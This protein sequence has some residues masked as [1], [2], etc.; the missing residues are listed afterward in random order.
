[1]KEY[2]LTTREYAAYYATLPHSAAGRPKNPKGSERCVRQRIYDGRPL[3][4][5][6]GFEKFGSVYFIYVDSHVFNKAKKIIQE[7]S[8][9]NLVC[10]E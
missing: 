2:K 3:P 5:T 6:I 10:S 1:M 9:N 7:N 4:D 8:K